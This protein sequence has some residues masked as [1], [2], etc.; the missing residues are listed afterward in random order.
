MHIFNQ[1][2][3]QRMRKWPV[4]DIVQKNRNFGAQFFFVADSYA[5]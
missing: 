2:L 1:F 5:F 4:A 3:L